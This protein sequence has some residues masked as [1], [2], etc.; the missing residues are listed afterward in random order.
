MAV[1][2]C[3]RISF[4]LR[5]SQNRNLSKKQSGCALP[6]VLPGS[7][8]PLSVPE[9][10]YNSLSSTRN[11]CDITC[12]CHQHHVGGRQCARAQPCGVPLEE[13]TDL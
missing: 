12:Y 3:T 8:I 6:G 5:G 1:R 9:G 2:P 11:G 4:V 13:T 7:L 10:L